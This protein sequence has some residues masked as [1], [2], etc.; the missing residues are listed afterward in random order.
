LK[1]RG[2]LPF[3]VVKVV[4]ADRNFKRWLNRELREEKTSSLIREALKQLCSVFA[5]FE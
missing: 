3:L 2:L 4:I 1:T 5:L